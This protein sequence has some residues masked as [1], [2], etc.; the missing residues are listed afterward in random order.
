VRTQGLSGLCFIGLEKDEEIFDFRVILKIL[1]TI[2]KGW[3]ANNEFFVKPF[4]IV[5]HLDIL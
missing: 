4:Q 1:D 3:V 5:R 2:F